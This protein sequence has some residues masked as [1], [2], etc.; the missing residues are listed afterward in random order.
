MLLA[1]F[2][3]LA[4]ARDAGPGA[5]SGAWTTSGATPRSGPTIT[6]GSS[7]R[8][9]WIELLFGTVG[10]TVATTVVIACVLLL[11]KQRRAALFTGAVMLVTALVT[12]GLKLWLGREP[13]ASGRTRSTS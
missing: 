9:A 8:C 7:S 12:T 1:L 3:V 11:R 2:A 5:R 10:M 13:A 6:R 4:R